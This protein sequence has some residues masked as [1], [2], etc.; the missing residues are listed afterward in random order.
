MRSARGEC[1]ACRT[2]GRYRD[3][4]GDRH[5]CMDARAAGREPYASYENTNGVG[6]E[7]R[8]KM[9]CFRLE[10]GRRSLEEKKPKVILRGISDEP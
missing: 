6:W 7:F 9:I 1:S 8:E 3:C 5:R 4:H 2:L 10:C